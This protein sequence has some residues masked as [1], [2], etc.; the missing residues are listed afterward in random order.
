MTTRKTSGVRAWLLNDVLTRELPPAGVAAADRAWAAVRRQLDEAGI[1][2]LGHDAQEVW[3]AAL[4]VLVHLQ[5]DPDLA[6]DPELLARIFLRVILG[7]VAPGGTV[8]G[9]TVPVSS[10]YWGSHSRG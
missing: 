7:A 6:D 10:A 1:D 8:D 9:H 4:I 2:P 3:S 5:A